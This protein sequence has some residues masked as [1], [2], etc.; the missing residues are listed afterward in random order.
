MDNE[1]ITKVEK[2][3]DQKNVLTLDQES[4]DDISILYD[5]DNFQK[6]LETIKEI[7]FD[8]DYSTEH[9]VQ[10][11]SIWHNHQASV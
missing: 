2:I 3:I 5:T 10:A 4:S 11:F 9:R 8:F 6:N 1:K 7:L